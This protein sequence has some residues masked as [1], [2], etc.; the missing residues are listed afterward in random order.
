MINGIVIG[1]LVLESISDIRSKS[2]CAWH[3][4]LFAVMGVVLNVI[5]YYQSVWSV[6]GG[7]IIGILVLIF[8]LFSKGAIGI[9]DGIIFICLGIYLGLSDNLRLLFFSLVTASI[10][11]GVYILIKKKSIKTQIPFVPCVLMAY[12]LMT[13]MEVLL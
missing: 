13:L 12:I 7:V 4:I 9:G 3:M 8:A 1:I 6:V 11:G 10:A 5:T 2:I